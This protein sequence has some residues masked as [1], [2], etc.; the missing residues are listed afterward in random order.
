MAT[1]SNIDPLVNG[2]LNMSMSNDHVAIIESLSKPKHDEDI[3]EKLGMKATIVRTLLN[4][5]H[6]KCLVEYDRTK[7]KK[8]GW[9]TYLWKKR[10]DKIDEYIDTYLHE[11]LD[12]LNSQ[13]ESE[14]NETVFSCSCGIAPLDRAMELNFMCPECNEQFNEFDNSKNIN[15]ITREIAKINRLLKKKNK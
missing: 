7:N 11:K 14:R 8:T 6:A 12:G 15:R 9:Y 13:L 2:I 5:L 1:K 3:A 10:G 4:D